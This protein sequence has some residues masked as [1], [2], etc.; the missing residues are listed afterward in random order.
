[1]A[2]GRGHGALVHGAEGRL[3]RLGC[4]AP[5]SPPQKSSLCM[6]PRC[7]LANQPLPKQALVSSRSLG[8]LWEEEGTRGT[9]TS[10]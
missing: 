3:P 1:M 8:A 6:A 2:R 4:S 7:L 9:C 5:C 10:L